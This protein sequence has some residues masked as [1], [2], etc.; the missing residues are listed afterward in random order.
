MQ[1]AMARVR[2]QPIGTLL[3]SYQRMIRDLALELGKQVE[4]EIESGQVELDREMIELLRDPLL[5]IVRNAIDHGIEAPAERQAAGQAP[6]RTADALG[7]ADRERDPHRD[8]GRW[9]RH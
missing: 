4:V 9:P 6:R 3:G 2:M 8:P 5:H 1:S 7:P